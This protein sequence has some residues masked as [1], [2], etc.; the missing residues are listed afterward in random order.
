M[1]RKLLNR[2]AV[3]AL[4]LSLIV[5]TSFIFQNGLALASTNDSIGKVPSIATISSEIDTS[6][7]EPV[8]VIVQMESEPVA[9]SKNAAKM[10][11][12]SFKVSTEASIKK[13]QSDVLLKA[14]KQGLRLR[15]NYEYNTVFNGMEVTLP[16]DQIP[17]LAEL[18]GV[19]AI[20][21]NRT[22]YAISDSNSSATDAD[23]PYYETQPLWQ[24]GVDYAWSQG[25]TGKGLKVGVIDTGVDYLHP[26][27]ANAYKGGYNSFLQTEDPYEE[28]PLGSNPGTSHGT[29]VAGTIVGT[30]ANTTSKFAQKGIAYEAGLYAYKVLGYNASTG[31]TS[32]TTAQ[33]IDGIEHAVKDG[34]DV[35]NLSLGSDDVKDSDSPDS[36]A[37]NNA[38]L[39]GTVVVIANGNAG[40]SYYSMGAPASSSLSISV[41]AVSSPSSNY[42]ATATSTITGQTYQLPIRGWTLG[43]DDFASLFGTD[44][45]DA[46]YVRLGLESD[47]N[48]VDVT[49]KIAIVSRGYQT[50]LEKFASAKKHGAKA[51]I[52]FNG[53]NKINAPFTPDLSTSIA[54][55]DDYIGGFG[56]EFYGAFD[57][58][59]IMDMKGKEG[60]ELA[61]ALLA[62][63]SAKLTFTFDSDYQEKINPGDRVAD[64]SSRGPSSDGNLSI[65]PDFVAPGVNVLSTFPAY[66]RDYSAAYARLD[67]TSMATPHITGLALLLKQAHPEWTPFD[68]RAALGNTADQISDET[69]TLYDVYSQG[70]GRVN[71]KNA[72]LTPALLQSVEEITILDKD[73]NPQAVTNYG[74]NT[75]F[76]TIRNGE[77]KTK[78][79]QLK[80]TSDNP[81]QYQASVRMH[82]SVTGNNTSDISKIGVELGETD[83]GTINVNANSAKGFSLSVT[84]T[85]DTA[86]GVYEGD[87]VLTSNGLPSLH[88]PFS[89]HVGDELPDNGLGLQELTLSNPSIIVDGEDTTRP[90]DISFKLTASNVNAILL[91]IYD[92]NNEYIGMLDVLSV[93]STFSGNFGTGTRIYEGMTQKYYQDYE[94][95]WRT[96]QS[97]P[98][99]QYTLKVTAASAYNPANNTAEKFFSAYK[100]FSVKSLDSI[101]QPKVLDAKN[102]FV[103]NITNTTHTGV[104]VLTLPTTA[105]IT[106]EITESSNTNYIGNNGILLSLPSS[107]TAN[108]TLTVTIASASKP[109]LQLKALV[110]VVLAA[111]A[112]TGFT[113]GDLSPVVTGTVD[114]I[115]KTVALTVPYGTDVTTL[116]PTI[117]HTG[118]SVSPSSGA[119]KDFT[120]P[121]TY[122]VTAADNST[123]QYVVTV[124]VA[125]NPAKAITGFAF[126]GLTPAVTGAVNESAKTIALTV[127]YG[128]NVTALV[129]TITHTGASVSP[130]SG[131][132]KDFTNPVTYTVMAADNSTQQYSVRVT[133]A[134][135]NAPSAPVIQSAIGGDG[136]VTIEWNPV[137]AAAGYNIYM[138]TTP[139]AYGTALGSVSRCYGEPYHK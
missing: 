116:V 75:S 11:R 7:S 111:K 57:Y 130:S 44:P 135:M 49:G 84:P 52:I 85:V 62:N 28:K 40:P 13:E 134:A 61:S 24:I 110:N 50:F 108:V 103:P 36:I 122:T 39:H 87:V 51:V 17:K 123:Q 1:L 96:I 27:L 35:I 60:R 53:N 125:A 127:P 109:S 88:L 107:G 67:G 89:I 29:H 26:D 21:E 10:G 78:Q 94:Y 120:N 5:S 124:T 132:A 69:G 59:P 76:G 66:G 48:N 33:V 95:Y 46:V 112:I 90:I 16:A 14:S 83:A 32:G 34:M 133:I 101:E 15:K 79:L 74:D 113:F 55:K 2:S 4:V 38:V 20:H 138:S 118:A 68:I 99:G 98:E 97:L 131:A 12:R 121:V 37:L 81:V 63:P 80:N 22:F 119:A 58:I 128:T 137:T 47:Y 100:T 45:V 65:K 31:G 117:T 25:L 23:H 71:V 93:D 139:G 43:N 72:L 136:Q 114:E 41:G 73:M 126:N 82:P 56:T 105:G 19:K 64:F 70:A 102:R 92:I 91:K 54:G 104:P 86:K 106:Y 42:T 129:P 6:S 3:L 8:N 9:V 30:A 18:P 77:T 115:A